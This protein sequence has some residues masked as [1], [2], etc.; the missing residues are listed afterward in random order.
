M[1][2]RVQSPLRKNTYLH[3][4]SDIVSSVWKTNEEKAEGIILLNFFCGGS[5]VVNG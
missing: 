4:N 5:L 1:A 2:T 3:V